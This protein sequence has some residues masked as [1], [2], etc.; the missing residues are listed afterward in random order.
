MEAV[1]S[2]AK[3]IGFALISIGM[4]PFLVVKSLIEML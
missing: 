4:L 3:G 2:I 1:K